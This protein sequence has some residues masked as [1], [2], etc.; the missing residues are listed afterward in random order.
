MSAK[1]EFGMSAGGRMNLPVRQARRVMEYCS[2][3]GA[4][5][6]SHIFSQYW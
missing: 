5:P 1:G 4:L 6:A 3:S 2:R